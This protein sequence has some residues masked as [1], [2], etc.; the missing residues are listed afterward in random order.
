MAEPSR[1]LYLAIDQGGQSTRAFVFDSHGV[2]IAEGVESCAVS[3]PQPHWVE[4]DAD[5]VVDSVTRSLA[6]IRHKLGPRCRDIAAAGLA[7]QRSSIVC[8][9]RRNGVPLSP[10]ISWQD[11]R[12][13]QWLNGFTAHEG[14]I[15]RITG[16]QLSAHYGVSKLRWCLDQV[17]S[18]SAAQAA[19]TLAW[20]PLAS[21]LVFRLLAEC[22]QMVD[23]ANAARTLLWD[24]HKRD[25][26]AD[27]LSLFGLPR[28]P[29]P[30]CTSS[31]H[32]FGTLNIDGHEIPLG[33]VT[34]DQS[35]ALFA[36]GEPRTDTAYVNI[37]TG[38][39]V[40]R[41]S[42]HYPGDAGQL[43]AGVVL[44]DGDELTYALE[45]TVNGAASA[46]RWFERECGVHDIEATLPTWLARADV[47]SLFLNGV[48]GLGSPYWV[49]DFPTRFVG[50]GKT[51]MKAVA[52]VESIA[53]LLQVNIERMQ[54]LGSPPQQLQVSGGLARL[55]GLCQRLADLSGLRVYRP[56]Q[57]EA[58]ARGT[59]YLAAGR[60]ATWRKPGH[61]RWFRAQ[62]NT[63]LGQRFQ[64]WCEAMA[65]SLK[66]LR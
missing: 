52:V 2:V 3:H 28:E 35:A 24:L 65:A 19:G 33:V 36:F 46:L 56:A 13:R 22:P 61:G 29:L 5:D 27:L 14:D 58:T 34:G 41:L 18:V 60:P 42:H 55:D 50:D 26:S 9:D 11:T 48:A 40:Q 45:G 44:H 64:A 17:K 16:L 20:G 10:V 8:W 49:A 47:P 23:P 6:H 53:F 54:E 66:T 7:S 15:R 1:A 57:C 21:F 37:G 59:A 51:W 4:Q 30:R 38:A 39:F 12:A 62:T 31:R 32:A 25:W 43:L 63:A